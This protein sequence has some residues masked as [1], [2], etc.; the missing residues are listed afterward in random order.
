MAEGY[1]Q[2]SGSFALSTTA[3]SAISL[4]AGANTTITLVEIGVS[5]DSASGR[6]H[7]ELC[8][9][10]QATAGTNSA[11]TPKQLYGFAAGDTTAPAQ[12]TTKIA[13]SA[14]PTV[15]TVLKEWIF[16]HPGPFVIQ[17]P[18]G[19]EVQSLVSGATKYKA[20]VLRLTVD[21]GTPNSF[22]Y[23]HWEE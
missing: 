13:F 3:K 8:E 19:R 18:L 6:C 2:P 20:L 5:V 22:S 16:P 1:S 14:E 9:S 21:T 10:T 11:G 7:V 17:F 12:T 23:L 15:L 4:I